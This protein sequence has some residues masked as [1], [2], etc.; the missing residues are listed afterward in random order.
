MVGG[1]MNLRKRKPRYII[2]ATFVKTGERRPLCGP[3]SKE[4][5]DD[6]AEK[7]R[8]C[9]KVTTK[10][11]KIYRDIRVKLFIPGELYVVIG[12]K[13]NGGLEHVTYPQDKEKT[14]AVAAQLRRDMEIAIPKYRI[15]SRIEVEKWCDW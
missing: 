5:A 11:Y 2:V 15:F 6:T 9:M 10:Q 8:F 4:K 3:V 12:Y 14:E 1:K 13:L 7:L